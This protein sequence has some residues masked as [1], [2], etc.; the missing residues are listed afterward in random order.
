M[1]RG[2][3]GRGVKDH[4][5]GRR[6]FVQAKARWSRSLVFL[7]NLGFDGMRRG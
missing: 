7:Y 6:G 4:G 2:E 3:Q 5:S 1:L